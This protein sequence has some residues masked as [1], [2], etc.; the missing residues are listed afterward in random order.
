MLG[1]KLS[2]I[3]FAVVAFS[4]GGAIAY[5]YQVGSILLLTV[6]PAHLFSCNLQAKVTSFSYSDHMCLIV[7]GP[8]VIL[9]Y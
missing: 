3:V 1:Q 8:A 9:W 5:A 2:G 7:V 4:N 6:E